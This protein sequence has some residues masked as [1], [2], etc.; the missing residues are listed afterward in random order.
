MVMKVCKAL[1]VSE[2]RA[3]TVLGQARKTQR[4]IPST[5]DEEV[6]LV[7]RIIELATRLRPVW[8]SQ[9]NSH[10]KAGRVVSE[11]QEGGTDLEERRFEGAT[12]T[13][14]AGKAMA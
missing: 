1:A 7:A 2:R 4:H 8:I 5:T 6:R 12:K 10:V 3:C 11:S 13:A 14:K 9:D